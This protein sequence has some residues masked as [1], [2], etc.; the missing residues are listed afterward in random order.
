M[1]GYRRAALAAFVLGA[2]VAL[3]A[4][5]AFAQESP[6][7]DPGALDQPPDALAASYPWVDGAPTP[8][9]VAPALPPGRRPS[10]IAEQL[11]EWVAVADDNRGLPFI[12]VD[13]LGA[14]VFAFDAGGEFLGSAPVL[15]G[16]ARGDD[17]APGVGDLKLSEIT[18][19]ERTTPAGRFVAGFSDSNGHG[20]MLWVDLPDA[21]SLH[22][23]MSVSPGEHRMQRI[24]SRDP[25]RHRISYGCINV[26]KSFYD[27]VVLTSLAGSNAVVYVLPDTKPIDDVFPAFAATLGGVHER[28]PPIQQVSS[29]DMPADLPDSVA[30]PEAPQL[31]PADD[32]LWMESPPAP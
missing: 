22:P 12:I 19:D 14:R 7:N 17:S 11:A 24:K 5:A 29:D 27:D 16:L 8:E 31:E 2:A 4:C 6:P 20:T 13:K 25:G 32:H 3:P 15:V 9:S 26:P 30:H 10:G 23:V 28:E 21:I 1:S 18:P